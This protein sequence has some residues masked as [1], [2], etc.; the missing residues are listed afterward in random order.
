MKRTDPSL[1]IAELEN[2]NQRLVHILADVNLWLRALQKKTV[3]EN[4]IIRHVGEPF[5]EEELNIF[6]GDR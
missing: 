2:D 5:T 3:I 4:G 6:K 1:R